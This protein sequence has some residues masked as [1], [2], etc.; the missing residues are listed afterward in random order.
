MLELLSRHSLFL[1]ELQE[2][3]SKVTGSLYHCATI[4]RAIK[5]LGMSRK[6]SS[7]VARDVP[8][9]E[10]TTYLNS[11]PKEFDSYWSTRRNVICKFEVWIFPT[12]NDS[13]NAYGKRL[14][15][16]ATMTLNNCRGECYNTY[17]T[18]CCLPFDGDNRWSLIMHLFI[19]WN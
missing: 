16:R 4:C 1:H 11:W 15:A 7:Q 12:W 19:M 2:E 3:L 18:L 17:N 5:R 9:K 6:I 10:H 8:F 14:S 13:C